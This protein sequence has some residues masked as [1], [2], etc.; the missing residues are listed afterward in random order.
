M[1]RIV[2]LPPGLDDRKCAYCAGPL[3]RH[4]SNDPKSWIARKFCCI[5]CVGKWNAQQRR[6]NGPDHVDKSA[7]PDK[8]WPWMGARSDKGYGIRYEGKQRIFAHRHALASQGIDICGKVV[9]HSCDNPPCCNPAH[10]SVGTIADNNADMVAKGRQ[11]GPQGERHPHAKLTASQIDEIR[12][13][14]ELSPTLARRFGVANSTIYMVRKG[15]T[16]ASV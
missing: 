6:P 9:M 5:Q 14:P 10:L 13:S 1:P 8:C 7:G 11:R 3:V 2:I 4:P 16:W 12:A 15:R